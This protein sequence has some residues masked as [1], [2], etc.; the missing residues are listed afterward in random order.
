M[1]VLAH[2]NHLE[3]IGAAGLAERL[4]DREHDVIAVSHRAAFQE[5]VFGQVQ[6]FFRI[7]RALEIDRVHAAKQRHPPPRFLRRS[8][9]CQG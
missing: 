8:G 4:T 6:R 5:L 3:R 9:G 2:F 1:P 7:A